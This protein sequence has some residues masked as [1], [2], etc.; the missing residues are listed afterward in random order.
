MILQRNSEDDLRLDGTDSLCV[1]KALNPV[2]FII[3]TSRISWCDLG[4][5]LYVLIYI[6]TY[7]EK[8]LK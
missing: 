4:E 3:L 1:S 2:F 7:Q 5:V 8:Y 6:I